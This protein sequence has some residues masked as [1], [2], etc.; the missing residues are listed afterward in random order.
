MSRASRVRRLAR[1]FYARQPEELAPAL[2]NKL[3][4]HGTRV[5]R[6]VE[7]EAYGGR[8]PDP[9]SHTF[10]G[11]TTRTTAMFGPPGHLYVYFSYGVHWCANVV[12]GDDGEGAAVLLRA[13]SPLAGLEE[14]RSDRPAA[15]KDTDLLRGPGNLCRALAITKD[16][17]GADLVKADMGIELRD[18]GA[19][20]GDF[21]AGP[22]VGITK[23]VDLPW[24][25]YLP[26]E[27]SVSRAPRAVPKP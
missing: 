16:H 17:Y 12:C 4:V 18:D 20:V 3:I 22:R 27:P 5:A 21:V 8:Q 13:A 24:R 10:R 14:M 25:F 9:A 2:L 19:P 6:I 7:V 26:N 11:L 1:D 15:R 23:A